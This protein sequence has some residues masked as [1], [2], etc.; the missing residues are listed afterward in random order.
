MPSK[1]YS[2]NEIANNNLLQEVQRRGLQSFSGTKSFYKK[3]ETKRINTDLSK[4]L[5]IIFFPSVPFSL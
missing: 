4:R 3:L 5:K 1:K 2:D